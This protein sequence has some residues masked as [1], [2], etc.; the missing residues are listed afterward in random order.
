VSGYLFTE[1]GDLLES[2]AWVDAWLEGVGWKSIDVSNQCVAS[3]EH[4]RLAVGLDYHDAC[5]VSGI[6]VGGGIESMSAGVN[7]RQLQGANASKA[8]KQI[9]QTQQ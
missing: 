3:G 5:P 1:K 7:V 8:K 4:V 6:R 9:E 2:H